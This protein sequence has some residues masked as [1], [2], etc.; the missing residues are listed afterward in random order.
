MQSQGQCASTS[1]QVSC[2]LDTRAIFSNTFSE[3]IK[4]DIKQTNSL[5][6]RRILWSVTPKNWD[7]ECDSYGINQPQFK[8]VYH[9]KSYQSIIQW[10]VMQP[11][12]HTL[13]KPQWGNALPITIRLSASACSDTGTEIE[14]ITEAPSNLS[15]FYW[16][17]QQA[18]MKDLGTTTCQAWDYRLKIE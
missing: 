8:R 10:W 7:E 1:A 2:I 12:A 15:M 9:H 6:S 17:T 18:F 11:R 4:L 14:T 13:I 3:Y 16:S 5:F